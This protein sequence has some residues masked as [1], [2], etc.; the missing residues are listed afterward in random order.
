MFRLMLVIAAVVLVLP[1]DAREQARLYERIAAG[2]AWTVTFCD[3]NGPTCKAAAEYW[4][5]AKAKAQFAAKMAGD[6]LSERMAGGTPAGHERTT[7][8]PASAP[9]SGTLRPDDL[10]PVWRAGAGR[11]G[12]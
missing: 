1:T 7:V 10:R 6:I 3:R 12:A 9:A 5:V 11:S 2:V 8:S 4:T